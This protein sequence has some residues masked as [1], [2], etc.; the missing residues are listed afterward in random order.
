MQHLDI[1]DADLNEK[2]NE[3]LNELELTGGAGCGIV[4]KVVSFCVL[5]MIGYFLYNNFTQFKTT[6]SYFLSVAKLYLGP[7]VRPILEFVKNLITKIKAYLGM[8]RKEPS[9]PMSKAL[10]L[11]PGNG[12][13]LH[14]DA[15]STPRPITRLVRLKSEIDPTDFESLINNALKRDY[16]DREA[17]R[18]S[19][20]HLVLHK[21][22]HSPPSSSR[23]MSDSDF[24][25]RLERMFLTSKALTNY[26]GTS[27]LRKSSKGMTVYSHPSSPIRGGGMMDSLSEL[28]KKL[29]GAVKAIMSFSMSLFNDVIEAICMILKGVTH[30]PLL[31]VDKIAYAYINWR[32]KVS[33]EKEKKVEK[34]KTTDKKFVKALKSLSRKVK[35]SK[36]GIKTIGQKRAAKARATLLKMRE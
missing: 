5:A 20:K 13:V 2:V 19:G 34:S 6:L 33:P 26:S 27:P 14:E 8:E 35:R 29:S 11:R 31:L 12:V 7:Y 18:R 30:V 3:H 10:V 9:K 25:S 22:G 24:Q 15:R 32:S 21:K 16:A 36:R 17:P 4:G 23:G 28:G 1:F